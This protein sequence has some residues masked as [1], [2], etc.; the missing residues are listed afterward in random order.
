M[1]LHQ[2]AIEKLKAKIFEKRSQRDY[3]ILCFEPIIPNEGSADLG[4][5]KMKV[6]V[7]DRTYTIRIQH[8]Y[9]DVFEYSCDCTSGANREHSVHGFKIR[10]DDIPDKLAWC[11]KQYN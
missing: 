1:T 4:G 2:K 6:V 5:L 8:S 10:F 3:G 11:V 7:E 9:K